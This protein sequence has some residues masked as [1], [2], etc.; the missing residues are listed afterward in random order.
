MQRSGTAPVNALVR[1]LLEHALT[2]DRRTRAAADMLL[3][4]AGCGPYSERDP[5]SVRR[6]EIRERR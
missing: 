2:D 5:R 1:T 6:E 3:A 4:I